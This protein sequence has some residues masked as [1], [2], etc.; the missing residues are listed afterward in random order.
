QRQMR[1]PAWAKSPVALTLTGPTEVPKANALACMG[2]K[3][4]GADA[5]RAYRVPKANALAC[6][7][8]KPGG[9]DAY[10]AYR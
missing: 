7:G 5:Y 10:R 4:G 1:W 3:P 6:M 9:V 2:K 8:K